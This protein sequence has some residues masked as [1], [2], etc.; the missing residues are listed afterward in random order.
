MRIPEQAHHD[1]FS[2]VTTSKDKQLYFTSHL[3]LERLLA[4]GDGSIQ[5]QPGLPDL[6]GHR[7]VAMRVRLSHG[8]L[9][10]AKINK[11]GHYLK[12]RMEFIPQ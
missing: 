3:S 12:G 9:P 11:D 5:T 6:M 2:S 1:S 7:Q 4:N 10:L 8:L